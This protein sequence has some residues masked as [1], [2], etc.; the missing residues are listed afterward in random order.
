MPELGGA[1][2]ESG[3]LYQNS[4]AALYLG[5]LC[6]GA[7]R[8]ATG[9]VVRVRVEAPEHVDD[10]VVTFADDH[11]VFVQAKEHLDVG[12]KA[13]V[14]L[15]TDFAAQLLEVSFGRG[16]DRLALWIGEPLQ[17]HHHLQEACLRASTAADYAEWSGRMNQDQRAIVDKIRLL[18]SSAL[19]D[20]EMS[21]LDEAAVQ[22]IVDDELLVLFGHSDVEFVS[23]VQLE[24]GQLP[25]W[26]PASSNHAPQTLFRLLRD[27]VGGQARRRGSFEASSLI[28]QLRADDGVDFVASPDLDQLRESVVA[29]GALLRTYKHTIAATGRHL[30]RTVTDDIIAWAQETTST[31]RSE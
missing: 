19:A 17:A 4:I 16:T 30:P 15:W 7:S 5:R 11:R 28:E 21:T 27:R 31:A 29:C 2:T 6:D 8:P 9:R 12:S 20:N 14:K 24:R 1:T 22:Q 18:V 23:L 25:F 3:I 13:W 26:M 10:I